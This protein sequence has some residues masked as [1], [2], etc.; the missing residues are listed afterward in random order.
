ML[1]R[2][3]YFVVI[4][5]GLYIE[6]YYCWCIVCVCVCV[7]VC[8]WCVGMLVAGL[9]LCRNNNYVTNPYSHRNGRIHLFW[10]SFSLPV[11]FSP[12]H[13]LQIGHVSPILHCKA[14]ISWGEPNPGNRFKLYSSAYKA[15][16]FP[17]AA[18]YIIFQLWWLCGKIHFKNNCRWIL[19][20]ELEIEFPAPSLIFILQLK[21]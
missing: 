15:N 9:W 20:I 19:V 5:H 18:S 3:C 17:C 11:F 2:Y 6:M 16:L 10:P 13:A 12:Y 14:L 4:F 21:P 1:N 7:C 8:V